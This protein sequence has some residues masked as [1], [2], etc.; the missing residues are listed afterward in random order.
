MAGLTLAWFLAEAGSDVLIIESKNYPRP[1]VCGEYLSLESLPILER[2]SVM[3]PSDAPFISR[4]GIY[5]ARKS[6]AIQSIL[7]LGAIG[8]SRY[9][10]DDALYRACLSKGVRFL[11]NTRVLSVYNE[12]DS[13]NIKTQ[14]ETLQARRFINATGKSPSLQNPPP[15]RKA[16]YLAAKF[17]MEDAGNDPAIT[18]MQYPGGYCGTSVVEG[19]L[20]CVCYLVRQDLLDRHKNLEGVESFMKKENPQLNTYLPDQAERLRPVTISNFAFGETGVDNSIGDARYLVPPLTGN[21]MSLAIRDGYRKAMEMLGKETTAFNPNPAAELVQR[22][23]ESK[24]FGTIHRLMRLKPLLNQ[25]V[26][27]T[28]GPII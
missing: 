3:L 21:G 6:E 7:P 2:M 19:G 17:H 5:A 10:L 4:L 8:I 20:R 26:E 15:E 16:R 14:H 25:I 9:W 28:F 1:R 27:S 24:A 13:Y 18:L 12:S 22:V 23:A 11:L